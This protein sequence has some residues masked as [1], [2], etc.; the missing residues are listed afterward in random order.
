MT[1]CTGS[2][3]ESVTNYTIKEGRNGDANRIIAHYTQPHL[4]YVGIAHREG[5]E[6][7]ELEDRGY[8]ILRKATGP[9]TKYMRHM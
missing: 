4:P 3:P 2:A 1:I 5:R 6:A 9:A 7:T 8:E